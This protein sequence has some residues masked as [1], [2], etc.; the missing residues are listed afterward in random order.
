MNILVLGFEENNNFSK[1][2]L[3]N[4]NNSINLD[5][6]YLKNDFIISLNQLKKKIIENNY[7]IIFSDLI[8]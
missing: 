6:L 7:D 8:L 2:L 3:D 1:I 4:I 5:C